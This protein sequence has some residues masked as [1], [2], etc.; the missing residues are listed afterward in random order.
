MVLHDTT[1]LPG[2]PGPS[3]PLRPW[4]LDDAGQVALQKGAATGEMPPDYFAVLGLPQRLGLDTQH[5]EITFRGLVR[6]LHPDRFHLQG[7]EA[8]A[9]AQWH[10]SLINDAYRT[11]RGF[12]KRV[13]Y[14]LELAGDAPDE[15]Y[16]PPAELLAHVFELNEAIDAMQQARAEGDAQAAAEAEQEAREA[17]AALRD[18]RAE[19]TAQL[20]AAAGQWDEAQAAAE[21]GDADT[22]AVVRARTGLRAALGHARYLD[23]LL[24]RLENEATH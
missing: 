10:T 5:L 1:L 3:A 20:H 24:A 19:V 16:R 17:G 2:T 15:R 22:A 14:V 21:Q 6:G 11:L 9:R 4:V 23:N 18:A 12:E 7:P 13:A 8:V